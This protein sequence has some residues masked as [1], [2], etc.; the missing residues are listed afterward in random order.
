MNA[1]EVI[2]LGK[3]EVERCDHGVIGCAISSCYDSSFQPASVAHVV[4]IAGL[5]SVQGLDEP[6]GLTFLGVPYARKSDANVPNMRRSCS[7]NGRRAC[8][9]G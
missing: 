8:S 3:L 6:R 2:E 7:L 4:N 1:C 5:G 9:F